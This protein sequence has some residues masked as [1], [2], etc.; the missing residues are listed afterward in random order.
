MGDGWSDPSVPLPE[1]FGR[2]ADW[3]TA[4]RPGPFPFQGPLV[5]NTHPDHG[6]AALRTLLLAAPARAV[7]VAPRRDLAAAGLLPGP[8]S[9]LSPATADAERSEAGPT[10]PDPLAHALA[11]PYD[12][13]AVPTGPGGDPA[14]LLATRHDRLPAS[15]ADAVLRHI[16]LHPGAKIL[17]AWRDA[18]IA[19]AGAAGTPM[20]KNEARARIAANSLALGPARLRTWELPLTTLRAL[21]GAVPAALPR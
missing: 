18:L 12:V 7:L 4:A 13:V 9:S 5:I 14:V 20:T 15:A 11:V 16:V 2:V 6:A 21:L 19:L 10:D 1:F 17:N 3:A 8:G